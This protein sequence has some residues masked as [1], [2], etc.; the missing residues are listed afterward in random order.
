MPLPTTLR[1]PAD[2]TTNS[3]RTPQHLPLPRTPTSLLSMCPFLPG[4][5]RAHSFCPGYPC[6][7]GKC[8]Y[9]PQNNSR[10]E[11]DLIRARHD[12]ECR[13]TN[14]IRKLALAKGT[15]Y[16]QEHRRDAILLELGNRQNKLFLK[17]YV[18]ASLRRNSHAI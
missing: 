15:R 8:Y 6:H 2:K 4:S 18:T 5:P 11:E 1:P 14:T 17:I 10:H 9:P 3:G 7:R 13:R 16:R 12:A